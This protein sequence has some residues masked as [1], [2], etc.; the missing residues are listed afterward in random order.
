LLFL[1]QQLVDLNLN[2][3][4]LFL[5]SNEINSYKDNEKLDNNQTNA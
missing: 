3:F 2:A 1:C 5:G 4:F